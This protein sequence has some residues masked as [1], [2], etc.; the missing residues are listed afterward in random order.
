MQTSRASQSEHPKDQAL[1]TRFLTF[2]AG[3]SN[4][5]GRKKLQ[6]A[7]SNLC[8]VGPVEPLRVVAPNKT[9]VS[10]VALLAK[11]VIDIVFAGVGLIA[12]F[13]LLAMI[14]AL[15]KLD[16]AGPALYSAPRA[17]KNGRSF[18]CFKFRTM[19][20]NADR[21]KANLRLQN[22]RQGAF[23]KMARDPR[24][25]RVGRILRRYSLDEIP[26]LWNVL[27]GDMSLVGPRPHPLDDFRF[28][29][30]QDLRRLDVTPGITGLWQVT[31]RTDPSF[32]RNMA[33]DLEYIERWTLL[34]DMRILYKTIFAVV[35]GTG[36]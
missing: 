11:R 22:E 2:P 15:I 26:Q 31:A 4:T 36:A 25:T 30:P 23:F 16:S 12:V 24:V 14:A 28:Y 33:L 6:S 19:V 1:A 20:Q 10:Q 3:N 9:S 7:V 32:Q 34:M 29:V 27:A 18:V 17:G 35:R 8:V 21:M 5:T 13:P